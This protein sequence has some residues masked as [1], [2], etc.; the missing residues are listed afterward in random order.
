METDM[1]KP[2]TQAEWVERIEE[3]MRFLQGRLPDGVKVR[4]QPNLT[5]D[6][7]WTV[8]WF[9]QEMPRIIPDHYE[10]CAVCGVIYDSES[11]GEYVDYDNYKQL[12]RKRS[13]VGK[14]FCDACRDV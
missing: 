13:E 4:H 3:L 5:P 2:A 9:L 12:G 7:A 1:S 14:C 11:E 10:R 8:V 6:A